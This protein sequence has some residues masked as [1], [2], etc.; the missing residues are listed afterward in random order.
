MGQ[1]SPFIYLIGYIDLMFDII[2]SQPI[3]VRRCA[4]ISFE[5][6]IV[7]RVSVEAVNAHVLL[8]IE[9]V[10]LMFVEIAGLGMIQGD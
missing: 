3:G 6:V 1:Y 10:I 7:Q 5:V 8:P 2:Y 4:R 9:N